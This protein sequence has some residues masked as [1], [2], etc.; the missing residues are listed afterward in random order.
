VA[1]QRQT[2]E[3]LFGSKLYSEEELAE[4]EHRLAR[5]AEI[6]QVIAEAEGAQAAASG[7]VGGADE[8]TTDSDSEEELPTIEDDFMAGASEFSVGN[9][10][11]TAFQAAKQNASQGKKSS[12]VALKSFN[13][14]LR[15]SLLLA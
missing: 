1:Y 8:E 3:A 14:D 15:E 13:S 9:P 2:G 6:E 10:K 5:R 11:A 4:R 12:G 7:V